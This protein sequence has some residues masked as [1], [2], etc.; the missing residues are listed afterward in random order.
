L[1]KALTAVL[2]FLA[3]C[4]GTVDPASSLVSFFDAVKA[5]KGSQ[6]VAYLSHDALD[7]LRTGMNL[8][9]LKHNPDSASAAL[10]AYGITLTPEEVG[11][12]TIEALLERMIESPLFMNMMEDA[13]LEVGEVSVAGSKA[14]VNAT[15]VFLGDTTS[16]TVEMVLEENHW[17][18]TGEGLRFAL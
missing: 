11:T 14:M 18:I 13:N 3:G 1:K 10:A 12:I 15:V 2:L 8:D 7:S 5:G 9:E 4:S 16:G 17:K 6:A